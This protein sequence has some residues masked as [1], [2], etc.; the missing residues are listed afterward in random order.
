MLANDTDPDG[1]TLTVTGGPTGADGTVTCTAGGDCT[2]T[3]NADFNGADSFTYTI[4]DGN[5]GTDTA[6]VTVTVTADNDAP[7]AVDDTADHRRGHRRCD[8]ERPAPTTPTP[9]A[10]R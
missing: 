3:P 8:H 2:Y 1:D 7:V 6:T 5:G 9:T 4:S 10:T